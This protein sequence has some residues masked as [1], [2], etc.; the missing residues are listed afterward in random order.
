MHT[1]SNIR[2][3]VIDEIEISKPKFSDNSSDVDYGIDKSGGKSDVNNFVDI[4]LHKE[5]NIHVIKQRIKDVL[6][7][8]KIRN[9]VAVTDPEE[10]NKIV[11]LR[12][13][14]AE[15]LGVYH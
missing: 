1:T 9:H 4:T 7:K 13:E 8:S 15:Q 12:K 3:I 14:H 10:T 5:N 6:I 11:I 2:K